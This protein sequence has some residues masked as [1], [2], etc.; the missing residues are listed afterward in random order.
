MQ[1]FKKQNEWV[2]RE[3]IKI[4]LHVQDR[5]NIKVSISQR[6]L[7]KSSVNIGQDLPH[8]LRS[9]HGHLLISATLLVPFPQRDTKATISFVLKFICSFKIYLSGCF[10]LIC[11]RDWTQRDK[12]DYTKSFMA[13]LLLNNWKFGIITGCLDRW[14][15]IMEGL[16]RIT[17]IRDENLCFIKLYYQGMS[18]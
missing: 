13:F 2:S 1:R 11:P 17:K 7:M 6:T 10:V 12:Y 3:G 14:E 4:E 18:L 15:Y 9:W 8:S 5:R 16:A